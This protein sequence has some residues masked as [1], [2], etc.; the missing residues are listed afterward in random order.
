MAQTGIH[1][2]QKWSQTFADS[3]ILPPHPNFISC[4]YHI[5]MTVCCVCSRCSVS[6][7]SSFLQWDTSASESHCNHGQAVIGE[8]YF[9]YGINATPLL[10]LYAVSIKVLHVKLKHNI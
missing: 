4:G 2:E 9:V 1:Y 3:S 8:P 10:L 6:S 7:D 5:N